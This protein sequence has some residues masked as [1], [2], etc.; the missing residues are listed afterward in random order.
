MHLL[1]TTLI[2][3]Y[4]ILS[5]LTDPDDGLSVILLALSVSYPFFYESYQLSLSGV[6]YLF[7]IWNYAD[8][9]YIFVGLVNVYA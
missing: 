4:I 3:T 9:T 2:M 8:M 6:D 7:D 1:N 5:Y